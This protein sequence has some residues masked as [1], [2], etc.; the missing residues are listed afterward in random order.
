MRKS[1]PLR[2]LPEVELKKDLHLDGG[3][4]LSKHCKVLIDIPYMM[5]DPS[6]WIDPHHFI[7]ERFDEASPFYLT[8]TG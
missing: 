8:P 2:F 5:N 4:T 3:I 7:P 6:N 1:L